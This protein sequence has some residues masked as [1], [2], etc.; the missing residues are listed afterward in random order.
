M[1]GFPLIGMLFF[2][3]QIHFS[4]FLP[5]CGTF[6]RIRVTG[7]PP[8]PLT[9]FTYRLFAPSNLTSSGDLSMS[10]YEETRPFSFLVPKKNSWFC[11]SVHPLALFFPPQ[12]S[13]VSLLLIRLFSFPLT[14][15]C[16]RASWNLFPFVEFL[17]TAPDL[18][19]S[20]FPHSFPRCCFL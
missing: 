5:F 11:F 17:I 10:L 12:R 16:R 18:L 3:L 20:L 14:C 13:V 6:L 7:S 4:S 9:T 1:W 2:F 19:L 8:R 15:V